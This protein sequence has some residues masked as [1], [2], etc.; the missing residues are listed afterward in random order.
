MVMYN[1]FKL[2]SNFILLIVPR[3]CFCFFFFFFFFFLFF[4]VFFFFY[5]LV[6]KFFKLLTPYVCFHTVFTFR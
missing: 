6:F 1:R 3:R 2:A 4:F 5:V